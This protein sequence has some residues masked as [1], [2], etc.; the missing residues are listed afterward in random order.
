MKK[1]L[2][3]AFV[4]TMLLTALLAGCQ[5]ENNSTDTGDSGGSPEK[6]SLTADELAVWTDRLKAEVWSEENEEG[7]STSE[8]NGFFLS[9]WADPRQL[10]FFALVSYF[11]TQTRLENGDEGYTELMAAYE[12]KN[13]EPFNGDV[14]I[15]VIKVS[16]INA[17][18]TKYAGITVDDLAEDWKNGV[19]YIYL[20]EYDAVY[21]FVSDYGPGEF[22]PID[23]CREDNMLILNSSD[24]T[25]TIQET[26]DVWQLMSH[27]PKE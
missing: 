1:I 6:V 27:L 13:G 25:L 4:L 23:G 19:E 22:V 9:D 17:V 10:D 5:Q 21:T 15:S 12:E 8:V 11:L 18:L 20:P 3:L 2:S 7:F 16:D 14:P 24:H 26:G